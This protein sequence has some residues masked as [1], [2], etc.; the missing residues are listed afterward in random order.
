M[1]N[2]ATQT[3]ENMPSEP[4]LATLTR[5]AS[6][7][8]IRN[9]PDD[10]WSP[11]FGQTANRSSAYEFNFD[12]WHAHYNARK[13]SMQNFF[14]TWLAKGGTI[15]QSFSDDRPTLDFTEEYR[16][17]CPDILWNTKGT[18]RV[19]L[20]G[21]ISPYEQPFLAPYMTPA[22][23]AEH[24]ACRM[25]GFNMRVATYLEFPEH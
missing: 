14:E 12:L 23:L 2:G 24:L 13:A 19:D 20:H 11:V 4:S 21:T 17:S 10:F 9:L 25:F 22:Y 15:L 1:N 6:D 3:L 18:R 8:Y 16:N 7:D 5:L